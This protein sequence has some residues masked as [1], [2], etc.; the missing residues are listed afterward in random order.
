MPRTFI[1]KVGGLAALSGF[2]FVGVLAGFG[3]SLV[4]TF[5]AADE[6]LSTYAEELILAQSMEE[7]VQR[8][9]A[10]GRAY[11]LAHD[12]R[13]RRAFEQADSDVQSR[14]TTL[15]ARVKSAEGVRLMGTVMR[16]MDAH[17]RALR[18]AMDARG[19]VDA[20]ARLWT[21]DVLP[22]ATELRLE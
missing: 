1:G 6:A 3:Y 20:V 17:D 22:L 19:T 4:S 2:L 9:L 13:S 10:R 16:G 18:G 7:A 11:L 14:V 5:R 21:A 15:Q 8:K 12:D